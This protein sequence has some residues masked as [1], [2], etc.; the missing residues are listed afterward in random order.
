MLDG[1]SSE[2][3]FSLLRCN[4]D[5]KYLK[6]QTILLLLQIYKITSLCVC[7]LDMSLFV[8][9][10]LCW[11]SCDNFFCFSSTQYYICIG[12]HYVLQLGGVRYYVTW[13]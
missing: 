3:R 11:R 5:R 12:R 8:K 13:L 4:V 10:L 7:V 2:A 6:L 9:V 1:V